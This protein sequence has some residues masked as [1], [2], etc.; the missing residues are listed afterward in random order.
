MVYS[1]VPTTVFT[2]LELGTVGLTEE[3]VRGLSSTPIPLLHHATPIYRIS[4]LY[5]STYPFFTTLVV[6][7]AFLLYFILH[8]PPSTNPL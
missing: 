7:P 5:Y 2:P 4:P 3:Q 1:Q 6:L 8:L